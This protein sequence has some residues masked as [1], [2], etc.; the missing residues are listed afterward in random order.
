MGLLLSAQ[1]TVMN[2]MRTFVFL[3]PTLVMSLACGASSTS[4]ADVPQD[5]QANASDQELAAMYC[6]AVAT[7]VCELDPE[8]ARLR[9]LTTDGACAAR[10]WRPEVFPAFKRCMS[11]ATC[12]N[13][14]GCQC[15]KSDDDCFR[16][17]GITLP[18]TPARDAYVNACQSKLTECGKDS[19]SFSDDWCTPG[20]YAFELFRDNT[21]DAL[22]PC[23]AKACGDRTIQTCLR[24]TLKTFGGCET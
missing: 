13:D 15:S 24:E 14:G 11:S 5:Q 10:R 16:E 22:A 1:D 2:T 17:V 12:T 18:V 21:Y 7:P 4:T 20:G 8:A 19:G 3:L 23:F 6:E 9:C